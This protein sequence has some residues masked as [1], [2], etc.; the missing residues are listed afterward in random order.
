MSYNKFSTQIDWIGWSEKKKGK[1]DNVVWEDSWIESV[2]ILVGQV[3][4]IREGL[5]CFDSLP[6]PTPWKPE[7][8]PL[9][10]VPLSESLVTLL[11]LFNLFWSILPNGKFYCPELDSDPLPL[12]YDGFDQFNIISYELVKIV[13]HLIFLSEILD[14]QYWWWTKFMIERVLSIT[15]N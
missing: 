15:V 6:T 8:H 13:Q 5:S 12:P 14:F 7:I 4:I 11:L 2:T 10:P 3:K 1:K 9:L